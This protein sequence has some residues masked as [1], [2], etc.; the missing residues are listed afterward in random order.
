MRPN[1]SAI[2][3]AG[4]RLRGEIYRLKRQPGGTGDIA[5]VRQP[6]GGGEQ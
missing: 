3:R 1:I 4:K 2:D 5:L 6:L